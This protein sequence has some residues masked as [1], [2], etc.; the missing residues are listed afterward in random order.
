MYSDDQDA[1]MPDEP[2]DIAELILRIHAA[3]LQPETWRSVLE[4]LRRR[5][6]AQRA[7]IHTPVPPSPD[8]YWHVASQVGNDILDPYARHWAR[9]D[10][11]AHGAL[12]RGLTAQ[13]VPY[14][15]DELVSRAEFRGSPFFNDFLKGHDVDR[16]LVTVLHRQDVAND[17]LYTVLTFYRAVGE[18]GFSTDDTL[19]IGRLAPHLTLATRNF[20][21]I[22][23]L[24]A[25]NTMSEHALDCVGAAL[26]AVD[27]RGR[28]LYANQQGQV[29]LRRQHWLSLRAGRLIAGK[30]VARPSACAAAMRELGRG[31]G[32]TVLLE[33]A[34]TGVRLVMMTAPISSA[35]EPASLPNGAAALI[36][37]LPDR[38]HPSAVAQ[39]AHLFELTA[40]E[41]RVLAVLAGNEELRDVAERLGI[42]IHTARSQLKAIFR[43]TGR[44]S[45]SQLLGLLNRMATVVPRPNS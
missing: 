24:V 28:L 3:P 7:L 13:G 45:Q 12:S 25:Q 31:I 16:Q 42:S 14:V 36:W 1:C 18:E 43:K 9:H 26:F 20:W 32:S 35:D 27:R 44:R 15:D 21:A 34:V 2:S 10:V 11:W 37:L 38:P 29:V 39:M 23:S 5:V 33:H 6:R 8:K 17:A 4:D 30:R 19:L 41:A 22:R 40:A